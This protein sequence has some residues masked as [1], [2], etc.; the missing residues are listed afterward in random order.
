M[1]S[2]LRIAHN[3]NEESLKNNPNILKLLHNCFA[4]YEIMITLKWKDK[5]FQAFQMLNIPKD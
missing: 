1:R 5:Q 4:T 2:L 3:V